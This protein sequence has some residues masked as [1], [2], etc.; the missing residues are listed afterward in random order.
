M[1]PWNPGGARGAKPLGAFSTVGGRDV[2]RLVQP[3]T[4]VAPLP[5]RGSPTINR[6]PEPKSDTAR[7]R[8]I[9][10]HYVEWGDRGPPLL[11]LHG[12]MRTS[13]SWDAV[14]RDLSSRFRVIAVDARG[15]GGSDWTPRGYAPSRAG[16]GPGCL[17]RA[18]GPLRRNRRWP[19]HRWSRNG[20]AGPATS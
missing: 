2:S 5:S 11:M 20:S 1:L 19:L 18:P 10:L 6:R 16:R 7:V 14:A 12:D 15:H 4:G 9:T 17:L 13:R 3:G 8:G